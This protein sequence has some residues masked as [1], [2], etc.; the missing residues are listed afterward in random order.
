MSLNID[1]FDLVIVA[2]GKAG[3]VLKLLEALADGD[4]IAWLILVGTVGLVVL[5]IVVRQKMKRTE[6]EF[7]AAVCERLQ[8][9]DVRAEYLPSGHL[10]LPNGTQVPI[11]LLQVHIGKTYTFTDE[12]VGKATSFVVGKM[13]EGSG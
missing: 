8:D 7:G 4:P 1:H 13:E 10:S 3:G 6:R 11:S 2:R 5:V 9:H 12:D